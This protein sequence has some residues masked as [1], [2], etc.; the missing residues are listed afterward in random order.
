[1]TTAETDSAVRVLRTLM[2]ERNTVPGT[3]TGA[4]WLAVARQLVKH[5]GD[6]EIATAIMRTSPMA[7]E[8][9]VASIN[10]HAAPR[11]VRND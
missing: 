4:A 8:R 3:P 2:A 6:Q 10:R 5:Y 9:L 11:R 7:R 1:M